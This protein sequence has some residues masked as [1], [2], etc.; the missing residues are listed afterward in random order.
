M[1]LALTAPEPMFSPLRS[2]MT[3]P[4]N[5]RT[6]IVSKFYLPFWHDFDD[7]ETEN[8]DK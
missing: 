6:V 3:V 2:P 5:D 4:G 1:Y 7:F 8:Q